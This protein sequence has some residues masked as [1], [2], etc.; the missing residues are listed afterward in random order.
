MGA[1]R[2]AHT[3]S[4]RC[5]PHLSSRI[6]GRRKIPEI[7][8]MVPAEK[9]KSRS[10]RKRW[11]ALLWQLRALGGR[12]QAPSPQRCQSTQ[13]IPPQSHQSS[14]PDSRCIRCKSRHSRHCKQLRRPPPRQRLAPICGHT[15]STRLG[16]AQLLAKPSS[17]IPRAAAS[18]GHF[19]MAMTNMSHSGAQ[20]HRKDHRH[21]Y[22]LLATRDPRVAGP[23]AGKPRENCG[24]KVH[25][26][27]YHDGGNFVIIPVIRTP[28]VWKS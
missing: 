18:W 4:V 14:E 3:A 22:Q 11:R 13:P 24:G 28:D 2:A 17:R 8:H 10:Q 27:R 1:K 9:N 21:Q 7:P 15:S 19:T 20:C 12:L 6:P 16:I 23:A 5:Y 26:G 25:D